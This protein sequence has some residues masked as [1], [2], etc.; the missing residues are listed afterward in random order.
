VTG[1]NAT[2]AFGFNAGKSHARRVADE[3]LEAFAELEAE[4][5]RVPE[6]AEAEAELGTAGRSRTCASP[7]CPTAPRGEAPAARRGDRRARR[8]AQRERAK[9]S[10]K[11]GRPRPFERDRPKVGANAPCPCGSGAKF[12][13]CHGDPK[14]RATLERAKASGDAAACPA[15]DAAPGAL[16]FTGHEVGELEGVGRAVRLKWTC[17]A[18]RRE[19]EWRVPAPEASRRAT[20]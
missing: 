5:L 3:A 9:T 1:R 14:W 7:A 16:R 10:A 12:K 15:C 8:R 20:P 19:L 18:C 2:P 17:R 4:G 13:R 11:A 6:A